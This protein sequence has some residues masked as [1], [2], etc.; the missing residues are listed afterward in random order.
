MQKCCKL[1]SVDKG[2]TGPTL[3]ISIKTSVEMRWYEQ[4][5]ITMRCKNNKIKSSCY[6]NNRLLDKVGKGGPF[7]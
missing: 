4:G 5:W 3:N 7:V 2:K 1:V 6:K